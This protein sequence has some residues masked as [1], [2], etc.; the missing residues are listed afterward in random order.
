MLIKSILA[1]CVSIVF[2]PVL[3]TLIPQQQVQ[4]VEF[5]QSEVEQ[6]EIAPVIEF[7]FVPQILNKGEDM[8]M[9]YFRHIRPNLPDYNPIKIVERKS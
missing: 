1:F 4:I 2:S 5:L 3:I 6:I 8:T 7:P 9:F